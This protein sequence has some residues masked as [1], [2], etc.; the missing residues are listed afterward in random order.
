MQLA[1][2][3]LN[4][5]DFFLSLLR[6][7]SPREQE[8]L[9][10]RYQLTGDIEV[11]NTLRQIGDNYGIT[12]ERVRQIEK[13]SITK[14]LQLLQ[15]EQMKKSLDLLR[16]DLLTYLEK[17]G[18]V[19][20]EDSLIKEFALASFDFD[21]LHLNSFLFVLEQMIDDVKKVNESDHFYSFWQ[22][23]TVDS[24]NIQTFVDK[25]TSTLKTKGNLL[26]E[27]E[28]H[29]LIE[30]EV[31]KELE[32]KYFDEI[33]NKHENLSYSDF[34][35]SLL[36]ITKKVEKNILDEWGLAEW[37]QVRPKK[38][39]D[40]IGLVLKKHQS[41]QHF[42]DIAQTINNSGFDRKKI[43]AATVHNELIANE[44][45]VLIGRGLYALKEWGY[46][47]GTVADIVASIIK[48]KQ[49]P[50]SKEDIYQEV[51][52]QRKVNPSTIYLS[53]INKK[54][55]KKLPNGLFDLN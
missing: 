1:E 41:P 23:K 20:T 12:R 42:R 5:Q 11:K 55:F 50:M 16:T 33:I 3:N 45:Y 32:I 44:N 19:A 6:Q 9:Q 31:I 39:A 28:L 38:L 8:V 4:F 26:Q 51:L 52:K 13:E 40:K 18:G 47:P 25:V 24:E 15:D 14:L 48:D 21:E 7:L 46:T 43:C 36:S 53:L 37:P 2:N 10:R 30:Q 29:D 54:R 17:K 22:I 49:K 35:K 27:K 34:I